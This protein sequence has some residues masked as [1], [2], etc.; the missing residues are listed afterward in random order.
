M[1]FEFVKVPIPHEY[2]E[3][4]KLHYG[5][6]YMIPKQMKADHHWGGNIIFD[7]EKSYEVKIEELKTK[8]G[9][10]YI[11]NTEREDEISDFCR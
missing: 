5:E 11:G 3:M 2:G 6:D 1:A 9:D 8:S 4:L 7:T 10:A